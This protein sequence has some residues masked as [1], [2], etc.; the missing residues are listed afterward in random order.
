MGGAIGFA[1]TA[2]V[3]VVFLIFLFLALGISFPYF[4]LIINPNLLTLLP[5]PGKWMIDFRQFLAFPMFA[6][7]GW[8]AVS[9]PWLLTKTD[10]ASAAVLSSDGE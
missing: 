10:R 5:K 4:V 3:Q 8:L 7:A 1:A 6:A 9:L 2:E